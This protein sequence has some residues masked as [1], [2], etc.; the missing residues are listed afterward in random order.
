MGQ[1]LALARLVRPPSTVASPRDSP[2]WK[3]LHSSRLRALPQSLLGKACQYALKLWNR[4]ELILADGRIEVDN[5]WVE[6]GMRPIALGRKNWLHIGSEAAGRDVAALASVV[7][8]C[9]RNRISVR[10]Y[11]Q[12]VL[13]GLNAVI[14]KRAAELTPLAWQSRHTQK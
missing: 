11:L 9:K 8:T 7:E 1:R 14:A 4:L 2:L 3:R 6:N 5:N 10:G 13:S 12:S